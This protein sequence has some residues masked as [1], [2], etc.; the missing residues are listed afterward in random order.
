MLKVK[1]RL[2]SS[3]SSSQSEEM[4]ARRLLNEAL[5]RKS[6]YGYLGSTG[7]KGRNAVVEPAWQETLMAIDLNT[8]TTCP[9]SVTLL[10]SLLYRLSDCSVPDWVTWRHHL[11]TKLSHLSPPSKSVQSCHKDFVFFVHQGNCVSFNRVGSALVGVVL[12]S[13]WFFWLCF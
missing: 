8:F 10:N 1:W 12:G 9:L 7:S 11:G 4:S 5:T 6:L 3:R 13:V 2:A